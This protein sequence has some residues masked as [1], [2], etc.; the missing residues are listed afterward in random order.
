MPVPEDAC[1]HVSESAQCCVRS[2]CHSQYFWNVY[3]R[4]CCVSKSCVA[5]LVCVCVCVISW[6][7]ELTHM[8]VLG[9]VGAV[10]LCMQLG[11]WGVHTWEIRSQVRVGSCRWGPRYSTFGQ[12]LYGEALQ[13]CECCVVSGCPCFHPG[14]LLCQDVSPSVWQVTCSSHPA[15][16]L[17]RQ[18]SSILG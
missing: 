1:A 11:C 15:Q 12:A 10:L 2:A 8:G 18:I 17:H 13:G 9:V 7:H 5:P 4:D 3:L 6:E 16:A 14:A